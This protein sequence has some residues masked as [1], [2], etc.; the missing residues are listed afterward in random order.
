[1]GKLIFALTILILM[2]SCSEHSSSH[3]GVNSDSVPLEVLLLSPIKLDSS[4][5]VV[6]V[7]IDN[8]VITTSNTVNRPVLNLSKGQHSLQCLNNYD[9]EHYDVDITIGE[10]SKYLLTIH[11]W[12]DTKDSLQR[13]LLLPQLLNKDTVPDYLTKYPRYRHRLECIDSLILE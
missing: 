13:T 3:V 5:Y 4:D 1:M 11:Y 10:C 7:R 12:I 8:K 9:D 6:S 2:S